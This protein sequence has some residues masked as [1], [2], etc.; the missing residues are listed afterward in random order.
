MPPDA[1]RSASSDEPVWVVP[2]A[3]RA[4]LGERYGPVYAGAEAEQHIRELS[5]FASCGDRVTETALRIGHLPFV[6]VVDFKTQRDE[7]I[8]PAVFE[9]LRRRRCRRV[10]NPAGMLTGRLRAA[11]RDLVDA[12]GGLLEVDGEEDLASLALVESLPT[13]ATVIYGIPGAGVSFVP[14]D[15]DA[16]ERVRTLINRMEPRRLDLG[17]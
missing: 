3:L 10:R 5:L 8:D 2:D 6:G 16:K 15:P 9:P 11:V 17:P 13:G 1:T 4:R 7:A 12:G 14:V